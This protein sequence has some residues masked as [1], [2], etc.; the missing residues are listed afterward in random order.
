MAKDA[1]GKEGFTVGNIAKELSASP[2]L[3]KKALAELKVKADFVKA[4]CS[5]Y[6]KE[7][8]SA[9]KKALK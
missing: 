4:G 7:R 5:Y 2:A 3:V 6:F 1:N 8:I 9:V